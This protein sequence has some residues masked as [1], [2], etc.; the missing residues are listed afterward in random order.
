MNVPEAAHMLGIPG[1]ASLN[2]IHARFREL[3]KEWHPDVSQYDPDLSH[4]RF[5]RIK[6]GIRYP[7]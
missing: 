6:R 1:R 7:C 4:D 5:I 2:G 3:A